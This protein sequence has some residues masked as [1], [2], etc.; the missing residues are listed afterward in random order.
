MPTTPIKELIEIGYRASHLCKLGLEFEAL[1]TG[2]ACYDNEDL[3]MALMGNGSYGSV[4][5]VC[6]LSV[7]LS[8]LSCLECI[9]RNYRGYREKKSLERYREWLV[10]EILSR[11][12]D[13]LQQELDLQKSTWH[14]TPCLWSSYIC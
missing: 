12:H 2:P 13:M 14:A 3:V 11:Y 1:V 8:R 4:M 7:P 10:L 6:P 9:L 5:G